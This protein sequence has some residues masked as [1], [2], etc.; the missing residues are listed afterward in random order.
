MRWALLLRGLVTFVF[1]LL[2]WE[3]GRQLT[4]V[5]AL[6]SLT[7]S[8]ARLIVPLVIISGV[9]GL[10]GAPWLTVKPA[11]ALRSSLRQ[12]PTVQLMAATVGMAIGLAIAALLA[13]P[14]SLLPNPFGTI[15][16]FVGVIV[17]GY[18]GVTMMVLRHREILNFFRF[19]NVGEEGRDLPKL[20]LFAKGGRP[21]YA[22]TM[23]LDTSVII[24]GRIADVA[25]TG[26]L[27]AVLAV[28]RFILNE[29]QYIADSA[30]VLRRNRGR[31][32][33]EILDRLQKIEG[34]S[35]VFLDQDP[36]EAQQVDEKLVFLAREM[37]AAI[38]TN[39]YNLNRV[40]KLQ[41]VRVLNINELANAVKSVVLPGE[42]MTIHVIQ[43]GKEMNQGVGYLD[44]G[45]MVVVEQGRRH[46]G[47][48]LSV[49]VT[50]VLQTNAGRLIFAI[51]EDVQER[52]RAYE[53]VR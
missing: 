43:E 38:V 12:I 17:M 4:G 3:L 50:K 53:S 13:Y 36:A 35:I 24:D 21:Q 49:R 27:W 9:V 20:P 15:L 31:R 25:E 39:D 1:V 8:S 5:E 22:D 2:G 30:E 37:S 46:M 40:A 18:L 41:G 14:L 42:E 23:L 7:L 6:E 19:P 48:R 10:V 34:V 45:T 33:L 29:L 44:D 51:P 28:P 32:G 47:A 26:F 52:R 11:N 16:P